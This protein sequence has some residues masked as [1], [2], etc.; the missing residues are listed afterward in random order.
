MGFISVTNTFSNGST[1]DATQVNQNFTDIING[2]SD[3]TKNIS[4]SALTAAGASNLQG[5]CTFGASTSNLIV[6][7][8]SLN[9]DLP[10][11]TNTTYNIGAATK[12]L[13]SV[14]LGG[15]STFTTR[16]LGGTLSGS[17]TLT[18]PTSAGT[19]GQSVKTDGSG[20]LRF[21][22]PD[23]V[24]ATAKTG[25]Y[26]LTGVESAIF[27]T[28]S[29]GAFTVNL[30]AVSSFPYK[31]YTIFRTDSTFAN[32]VTIARAGSDT[33]TDGG[34]T[35]ATSLT[36]STA[37]E[38]V[39]LLNDGSS[40]W[41]VLNRKTITP[42][43]AYTPT[44]SWVSNATYSGFW[45]RV[46][47]SID[48]FIKISVTGAVTA[49]SLTVGLPSGVTIDTAKLSNTVADSVPK[50]GSGYARQNGSNEFSLELRY[51]STSVVAVLVENASS[52]YLGY[53]VLNA[54]S[55]VT[56]AN[57]DALQMY[58]TVPVSGWAA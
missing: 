25:T 35:G 44:G 36:L 27:T 3:G 30:P 23:N 13:L 16:I 47:D 4:I 50:L 49:A 40:I 17:Y 24:I 34:T 56:W 21:E 53:T 2:T 29:G 1:A 12:G 15:S 58:F 42:W 54:T 11:N 22:Y 43:V 55:P 32:A 31:R 41:Y 38:Q 14:Y 33:I 48:V 18:L 20:T 8:G 51:S 10:I 45:R 37:G 28:A 39:E 57:N 46:G 19:T 9:S 52:T 26:T 7:N 6:F 5:A